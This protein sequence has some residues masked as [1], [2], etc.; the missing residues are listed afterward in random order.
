MWFIMDAQ[1]PKRFYLA[2]RESKVVDEI[3][4]IEPSNGYLEVEDKMQAIAALHAAGVPGFSE[5]SE[6]KELGLTLR[7]GKWKYWELQ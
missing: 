2:N 6:A 7:N 3:K 1:A 5:K 4:W